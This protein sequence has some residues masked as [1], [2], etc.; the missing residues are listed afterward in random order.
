MKNYR[1][2]EFPFF[3]FENLSSEQARFDFDWFMKAIPER[4]EILSTAIASQSRE[5]FEKLDH[6]PESLTVLFQWLA[7]HA[8]TRE[9]SEEERKGEIETI[10]N[11]I[12]RERMGENIVPDWTWTAET[13]SLCFD[14]GI[15]LAKV[16]QN[17]YK[18]IKWTFLTS[19]KRY[20]Y[21]NKPVLE[22]FD[23]CMSPSDL[24]LACLRRIKKGTA[25]ADELGRIYKTWVADHLNRK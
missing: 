10:Q 25:R 24:T 19:P 12:L 5:I 22:G 4:L 15:Y 11:P 1:V 9:L 14:T 23:I 6:S 18:N 17:R 16:L 21:V 13:I 2:I 3:P 8:H 7:L 20:I